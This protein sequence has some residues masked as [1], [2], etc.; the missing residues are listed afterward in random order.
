MSVAAALALGLTLTAAS[1]DLTVIKPAD[2]ADLQ[3]MALAAVTL[4]TSR[5]PTMQVGLTSAVTYFYGRLQGRTPGTDWLQNFSDYLQGEP[6]AELEAN[7]ERCASM[8]QTLSQDFIRV[9]A[10]MA[11]GA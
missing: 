9:G 7:R 11:A 10:K 2:R 3:C 8:M 6:T 1:D 4:G 5:D